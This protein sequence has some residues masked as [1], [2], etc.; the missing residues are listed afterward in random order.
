MMDCTYNKCHYSSIV[1]LFI[2]YTCINITMF[3]IHELEI[4]MKCFLD[5]ESY[6][7]G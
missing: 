6:R 2:Q 5:Y 3:N 4:Y 1:S 7:G